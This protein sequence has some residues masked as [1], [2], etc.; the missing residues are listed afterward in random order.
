MPFG[1]KNEGETYQRP[2]NEIFKNQIR[3]NI[4]VYV[5]NMLVKS[6]LAEQHLSDLSETFQTLRK[7]K[8]K[9]NPKKCAFGVSAGKFFGF[10]ISQW[11]IEANPEKVKAILDIQP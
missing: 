9:L 2:I 4:E 5:D 6:L 7:H 11:G 3:K 1:Q 10:M 8:M